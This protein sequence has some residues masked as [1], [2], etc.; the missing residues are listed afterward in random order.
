MRLENFKSEHRISVLEFRRSSV[1]GS[2]RLV[3]NFGQNGQITTTKD[4]DNNNEERYIYPN[5]VGGENSWILS[6]KPGAQVM[7]VL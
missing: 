3:A 2:S 4:Y 1:E 6:N 7:F 5:P